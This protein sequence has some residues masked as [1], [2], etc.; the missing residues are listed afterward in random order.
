MPKR[1]SYLGDVDLVLVGEDLATV[2][3]LVCRHLAVDHQSQNDAEQILL[4][5]DHILRK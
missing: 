3:I 5:V 1:S 2:K 4:P